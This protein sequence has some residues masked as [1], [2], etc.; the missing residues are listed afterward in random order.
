MTDGQRFF[1][2]TRKWYT[3]KLLPIVSKNCCDN[4]STSH[5]SPLQKQGDW[6]QVFCTRIPASL[7]VT[8]LTTK[9]CCSGTLTNARGR[10]QLSINVGRLDNLPWKEELFLLQ[11]SIKTLLNFLQQLIRFIQ[12]SQHV[13]LGGC[14]KNLRVFHLEKIFTSNR[15]G[16]R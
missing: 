10:G 15:T 6:P 11:V 1:F 5:Y 3:E 2:S 16:T 12:S 7:V 8:R 14:Q 4:L 9:R 13:R